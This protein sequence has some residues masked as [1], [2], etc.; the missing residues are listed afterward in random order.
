MRC[1]VHLKNPRKE[2]RQ[3][4]TRVMVAC[5]V[6]LGLLSLLLWRYVS[7]QIVD[8]EIYRT[9]SDRNRMHWLPIVPKR[10][11]IFDRNGLLLAE[12][13]PSYSLTVV[14]EH[15]GGLDEVLSRLGK[16]VVL[17]EEHIDR[18]KQ[19][20]H[21]SR[22]F[23]EV[24]LKFQLS[25]Q[26][27]ATVAVSNHRL[28]G[29]DV[30][31]ELV[32]HYPYGALFAHVL[33]Y[34]G[35]IS[36]HD[37]EQLD[38]AN[39]R[40]SHTIGKI[41]LESYYESLLH[42]VV[43]YQNVETNARGR[44]LRIL[45]R[46]DPKPG[47]D[48]TLHLDAALQQVAFAALGDNRGAVVAIDPRS[49]GVLALVSTPSF[50]ANLF[51]T[52]ISTTDYSLLRDSPDLPLFNRALQ[53]QYPPASTIKPLFGLA[54]LYYGAITPEY[55][56]DDPGWYKLPHNDRLYRD[57]KRRGHGHRVNLRQALAESCDVYYYDLAYRLGIDHLHA[58]ATA[59]GLGEKTGIDSTHERSGLM[60]SKAWKQ[61]SKHMVWFPGDT[62][63]LGIGQGYLLATP[64]QLAV[65][66]AVIATKGKR[67]VPRLLKNMG[68]EDL[69]A[70]D[71]PSLDGISEAH[72]DAII[73]G[74]RSVVHDARGTAR[75][76]GQDAH[77]LMAGK[78]GSAQVV[79]IKQDEEYDIQR[80]TSRQ[81]DHA[82]FVGFAPLDNPQIAVAVIVENGEFGGAVAAP[83]GRQL[84]DAYLEQ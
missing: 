82:L 31:A 38:A 24:P 16:L 71:L 66:T 25:E 1:A 48:I 14:K 84:F 34:V 20:L 27:I 51:V 62:V 41:G 3:F 28:P 18:F 54:G 73:D 60:P 52:G 22:P 29:V 50:D 45:E 36:E 53:G 58:F 61:A 72:W 30:K 83:I 42:G 47:I 40:G 44:I 21:R 32:R 64:L 6:L 77:Y 8:H 17:E 81:R 69:L 12:N 76:I 74:M 33:G 37:L 11:L 10:G 80:M 75:A 55:T 26:E 7:L 78:S 39:Y 19:R 57:W 56:I 9:Q 35:R 63:N 2:K 70:P 13:S 5:A 79:S 15:T 23:E 4:I 43:G 46:Q 49:G 67:F 59:F 65:T 68:D